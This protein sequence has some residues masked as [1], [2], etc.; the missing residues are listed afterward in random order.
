M[1]YAKKAVLF[2]IT[3]VLGTNLVEY[4]LRGE[5]AEDQWW[6]L[7]ITVVGAVLVY[8]KGN[9]PSDPQAKYW[10]ALFVPVVLAVQTAISDSSFGPEELAPVLIALVGAFQVRAAKNVGDQYDTGRAV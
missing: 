2:V 8:V 4:G 6:T 7:A 5:W 10:I 9:T 3:A 1:E